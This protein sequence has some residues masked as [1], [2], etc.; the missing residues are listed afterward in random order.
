MS[1]ACA[2]TYAAY[3]PLD[4][5]VYNGLDI[6]AIPFAASVPANAPLLFAGRI[7]PEKGVEAAIEIA[8]QANRRLMLAGGIYDRDYYE[9]R[10]VPRLEQAGE[11]V[12]F[13][14]QLE[15]AALWRLMGQVRGLL[16]PSAWDEPFGLTAVEAMAAGTPVI[17]FRRGA[18]EEIIRHGETGFLVEPGHV[19]EA[20]VLV[21]ELPR[22]VR[23]QCRA[24]VEQHF[25]FG[26]M[27]DE[28]E[29]IYK[30]VQ[31]TPR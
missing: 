30:D 8:L 23:A 10:I 13:L 15:H 16:F 17:A 6:D 3:T 25:S 22:L 19:A 7:A 31:T 1:H 9:E 24:H 2:H 18:A 20:A 21:A 28:Y 12:T 27:L 5:V 4:A 26:H 29:R 11:R 14:G